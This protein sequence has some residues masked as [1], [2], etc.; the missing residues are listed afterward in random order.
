MIK[1]FINQD[2]ISKDPLCKLYSELYE[3]IK[4]IGTEKE[5]RVYYFKFNSISL[6]IELFKSVKISFDQDILIKL[7]EFLKEQKLTYI[8]LNFFNKSYENKEKS[9]SLCLQYLDDLGANEFNYIRVTIKADLLILRYKGFSDS[10]VEAGLKDMIE[11]IETLENCQNTEYYIKITLNLCYEFVLSKTKI[12]QD[13]KLYEKYS[14][15]LLQLC[16]RSNTIFYKKL[17]H[18]SKYYK[19]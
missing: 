15:K 2:L 17:R 1:K 11:F 18:L 10:L 13:Q 3:I 12:L 8:K 19:N 4:L 5:F 9:Y 6:I 7:N 16:I 14:E